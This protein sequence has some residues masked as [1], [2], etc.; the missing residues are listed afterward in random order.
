MKTI[1]KKIIRRIGEA[2][3]STGSFI[4]YKTVNYYDGKSI[5][6]TINITKTLMIRVELFKMDK[7]RMNQNKL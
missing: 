6:I 5:K 7:D 2:E 1:L 4:T 3:A